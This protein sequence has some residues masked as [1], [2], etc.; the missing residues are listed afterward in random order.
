MKASGETIETSGVGQGGCEFKRTT[1]L[2]A[3]RTGAKGYVRSN[4]WV[5]QT[6]K[7][8]SNSNYGTV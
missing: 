4:E 7:L 2:D 3:I 8:R 1:S 5:K 6:Q